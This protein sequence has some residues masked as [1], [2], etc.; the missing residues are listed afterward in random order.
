MSSS[1]TSK[2]SSIADRS[3]LE[4]TASHLAKQAIGDEFS[5]DSFTNQMVGHVRVT[6]D[7]Y[8]LH[9]SPGLIL[10]PSAS[11]LTTKKGCGGVSS[12][13]LPK[14]AQMIVHNRMSIFLVNQD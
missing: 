13:W 8:S 14:G 11:K 6:T 1:V 12:A 9:F 2:S 7:K 5:W 10:P 4:P 3:S